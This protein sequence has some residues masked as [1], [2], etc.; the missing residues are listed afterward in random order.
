MKSYVKILS[1]VAA[2]LLLAGCASS[3]SVVSLDVPQM[4]APVGADAGPVVRI[5]KVEDA[6]QF[7]AAPATPD[8]PS[9]SDGNITDKAATSRAFARKRNT[10]GK[11]MG[12]VSLPEGQ[13]VADVVGSAVSAGFRN[14]GY[15]VLTPTDPGY[16]QAPVVN[17]TVK[18]FWSWFQ[19][20][21]WSVA[22]HCKAEV[23]VKAPL[24]G[25]Q[26][27]IA[28]NATVEDHMQAVFESDWQ[29]VASEGL[30]DL[31]KDLA[32][33]LPRQSAER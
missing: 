7:E 6:R 19:P 10:Y 28:A 15:R 11:A 25:L 27:G 5:A 16:D 33:K 21:F 22:I 18:Q 9:L 20:G 2:L 13:T 24:A 1:A 12:D 3:R 23:E 29:K 30:A 4:A 32:Q 8:I 14:A 17:A 26:S 31:T